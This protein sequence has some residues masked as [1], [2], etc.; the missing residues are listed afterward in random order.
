METEFKGLPG[1][2]YYLSGQGDGF[3][4][5]VPEL[6]NFIVA[7]TSLTP[8]TNEQATRILKLFFQEIRA[9]MLRGDTVDIRGLGS[10]LIS[11]PKTTK[12]INHVFPK[13]IPKKSLLK[14]IRKNGKQA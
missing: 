2:D 1:I 9:A 12:T 8:L 10:F 3:P 13:F 7:I 5:E 6:D 4:V 14:R 11:S